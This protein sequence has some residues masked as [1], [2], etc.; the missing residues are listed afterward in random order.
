ML[1]NKPNKFRFPIECVHTP[2][3]LIHYRLST[4]A[5]PPFLSSLTF[6]WFSQIKQILILICKAYLESR[7]IKLQ[8][9]PKL[10]SVGLRM[11][12]WQQVISER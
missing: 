10:G 3:P 1:Q 5:Y 4:T 9:K 12:S 6:Q 2:L 7:I 8:N 11:A